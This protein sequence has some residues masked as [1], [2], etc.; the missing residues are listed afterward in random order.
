M[1]KRERLEK[2]IA[3][4]ATD[5][6]PVALWRHF[7][8]DDQRA[9][10]LAQ[11]VVE[12]QRTYDWDLVKVTPASTYCVL[13]YGVQDEWR[14]AIE[15]NR[16]VTK[17]VVKRSLDWT[18]LRVLDPLRGEL[19]KYLECLRMVT[20]GL[21]DSSHEAP[22]LATIF[23]PLSHAKKLAG[24]ELLLRQLRTHPDRLRS[25]LNS[26]TESVLRF[27]DALRR[28]PIAGIFYAMQHAS[29]DIMSQAEYEAFGVPYDLKILESL[30][31]KW[32]LNMLHLHGDAP[33]FELVSSYPAQVLNWHDRHTKPDLPQGKTLFRGAVCGGLAQWEDLHQ[34]T[35]ASIGNTAR[36]SIA[37]T[38]GRRLILSTGCV[39]LVTTPLSNARATRQ[40]VEITR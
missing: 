6:V 30:P 16:E 15:G 9:A 24:Q 35:P 29:F 10:D 34:G 21:T 37:Q 40:V 23:S 39:M 2:T 20:D 5:R 7:P 28:L 25:G 18:E 26:I 8:G 31:D 3:G 32:W 1:N 36:D 38:A 12:F 17:Y 19:G 33:M 4:E 27:I 13:D 22:V 11:S 14:G